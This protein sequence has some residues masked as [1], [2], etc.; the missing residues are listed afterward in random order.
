MS[1]VRGPTPGRFAPPST[2]TT[3]G[4]PT[5]SSL[6]RGDAP[7]PHRAPDGM[8]VHAP[9]VRAPQSLGRAALIEAARSKAPVPQRVQNGPTCGL[10]ALGMVMDA[11]HAKD[12][13]NP[14][15]LVQDSDVNGKGKNYNV[16]PTTPQRLLNVA[17][18]FGFT[19]QGEMFT[20]T[21]LGQTAALFGY[22]A[23]VHHNATLD[24]LY[25]V[26]DKGHPAIVGFD[27]DFNGNP[28]DYDGQRAHYA[29]IEG[30]FDQDGERY[31]VARH[32]WGFEKDHVWRAKDFE[33]SWKALE[34]TDFYGTPG[35]GVIPSAPGMAEPSGLNLPD[36]GSG[37]AGIYE[38]LALK[39]VEVVPKGTRTAGGKR[40]G[41]PG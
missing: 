33:K 34:S 30:Y 9:T 11:W 5:S 36:V 24:A 37:K 29:V 25:A 22:E 4:T 15:A 40:V 32:G 38:S 17:R 7:A 13:R 20:A 8:E 27:V 23:S 26:L 21:Q 3:A 12:A 16:E 31:L 39:I 35:D 28:G 2:G 14:T 6:V 1:S 19:A 10:Y 41:A 18:A